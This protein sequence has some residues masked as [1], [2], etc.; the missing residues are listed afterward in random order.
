[1]AS[2]RHLS[3]ELVLQTLFLYYFRNPEE[4]TP[5]EAFSYVLDEFGKHLI[6][7]DFAES[8]YQ[9]V[10]EHKAELDIII[11]KYAPEWPVDKIAPIDRIIL[12]IGLFE[13]IHTDVPPLVAINEAVEI[14]KTYGEENTPKFVNGVLSSYAHDIIGKE[15]LQKPRNVRS[16]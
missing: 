7:T 2:L 6:E 13:L 11:Q 12:E 5:R 16:N 8:L 1:M 4:V 15:N 9:G 14:A 10:V 3:R